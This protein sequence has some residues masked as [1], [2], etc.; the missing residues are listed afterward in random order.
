MVS[1]GVA[2]LAGL[3]LLIS[4][5]TLAAGNKV[6][7]M[8]RVKG[9]QIDYSSVCYNYQKNTVDWRDC[10]SQAVGVFKQRCSQY[11]RQADK[12][13]ASDSVQNAALMYCH[14]THQYYPL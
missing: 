14:A 2:G 4:C 9:K 11:Q 5:S 10:R 12:P 3:A 1:K 6:N 8:W 7:V 13:G